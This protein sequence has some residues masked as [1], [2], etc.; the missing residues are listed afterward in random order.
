M[1]GARS[2]AIPLERKPLLCDCPRMDART[3]LGP[4][5]VVI[6]ALGLSAQTAPRTYA[7]GQVWEYRTRPADAG[8]LLKIQK[9]TLLG[10]EK[11]YHISVIGVHFKRADIAGELQHIP[12]SQITLD[13]SVTAQRASGGEFPPLSAVEEGIVGWRRDASGVFNIPVADIVN[14]IDTQTSTAK[15]KNDHSVPRQPGD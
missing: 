7:E 3:I 12:V 13:S 4:V 2:G 11:V 1:G 10:R 5:A 6:A 15:L 14:I 9:I 8:S